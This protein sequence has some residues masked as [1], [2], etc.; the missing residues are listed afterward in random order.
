MNKYLKIGAVI[1][2]VLCFSALGV[3]LA[4]NNEIPEIPDN[5]ISSIQ[6]SETPSEPEQPGEPVENISILTYN[7]QEP[8]TTFYWWNLEGAELVYID[9]Y[10]GNLIFELSDSDDKTQFSYTF[11]SAGEYEVYV[12]GATSL[13]EGFAGDHDML[14]S[15]TLGEGVQ[16]VGDGAFMD[17]VMMTEVHMPSTLRT[18]GDD[19]FY[20]C[21]SLESIYFN[22]NDES[23]L[24]SIGETA[25]KNCENLSLIH[26]GEQSYVPDLLGTETFENANSEID[27]YLNSEESFLG[28]KASEDWRSLEN[29]RYYV[30][31]AETGEYEFTHFNISSFTYDISTAQTAVTWNR[32]SD[33]EFIKVMDEGGNIV[34]LFQTEGQ[35]DFSYTFEGVGKYTVNMYG[36]TTFGLSSFL[37]QDTLKSITFGEGVETILN[38]GFAGCIALT[39]IHFSPTLHTLGNSVFEGAAIEI[40][41][42]PDSLET[43]GE[44]CFTGC[45]KLKKAVIGNGLTE[46]SR[47]TFMN[48]NALTDITLGENITRINAHAFSGCSQLTK[49]NI[50]AKVTSIGDS[51]F[52][53][54]SQLTK[55]QF[56]G[57][58]ETYLAEIGENAFR[59]DIKLTE[60]YMG[61]QTYVPD[62]IGIGTET[63]FSVPKVYIYLESEE[64]LDAFDSVSEWNSLTNVAWCVKNAETGE[65]E[66]MIESNQ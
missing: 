18:I 11:E 52:A 54:C 17:C 66:V 57:N 53:N 35:T 8:N 29:I 19:A 2:A 27:L 64:A 49:I 44:G 45:D 59:N 43:M 60:I 65:Y 47:S 5:S 16:S 1:L 38:G 46:V 61:E 33:V 50:P 24:M 56:N 63:F 62:L 32:L 22:G 51:C 39:E 9:D 31:N 7:I 13:G 30:K 6:M 36:V 48:C 14:T 10:R 41:V 23:Y 3:S 58:N 15:V 21:D 40:L 12:F 34:E 42:I 28:Y 4:L 26:M 55:V 25:F 37:A 20:S